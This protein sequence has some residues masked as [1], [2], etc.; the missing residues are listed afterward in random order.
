VLSTSVGL[1]VA[2][3]QKKI[4]TLPKYVGLVTVTSLTP[5]PAGHAGGRVAMQLIGRASGRDERAD[6]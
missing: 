3:F 1:F 6:Q 2:S 4:E 5:G